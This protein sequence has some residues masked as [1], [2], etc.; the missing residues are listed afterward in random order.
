MV[1]PRVDWRRGSIAPIVRCLERLKV[2][3]RRRLRL[4]AT[5]GSML[6]DVDVEN[7]R[8]DVDGVD[9]WVR[10]F[11]TKLNKSAKLQIIK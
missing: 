4:R 2:V 1:E 8:A 5:L 10:L 11:Q 7:R 9:E 3:G 6:I